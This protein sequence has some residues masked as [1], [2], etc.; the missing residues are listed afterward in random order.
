[1]ETKYVAIP[2]NV[3]DDITSP[4]VKQYILTELTDAHNTRRELEKAHTTI[5][6]QNAYIEELEKQ[7]SLLQKTLDAL[8]QNKCKVKKTKAVSKKSRKL[9]RLQIIVR[10]NNDMP[11]GFPA[12]VGVKCYIKG[13]PYGLYSG[14]GKPELTVAEVVETANSL[15]EEVLGRWK[16]GRCPMD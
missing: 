5:C 2:A 15:I 14:F 8:H 7:V 10:E 9:Q 4:E 11:Y 3:L 13:K 6:E 1:M 12:T 16:D